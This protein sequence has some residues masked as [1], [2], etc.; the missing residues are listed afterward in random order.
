L[1]EQVDT[2]LSA[3]GRYDELING[4]VVNV[5]GRELVAHYRAGSGPK[6]A[7]N[8]YSVTKTVMSMLI[9]IA[10]QEGRIR[11]VDAT[12]AELLPQYVGVMADGVGAVTLR[13]LL[14]MTGGLAPDERTQRYGPHADWTK[15]TLSTPLWQAPGERFL[16]S[17][18]GAHLLSAILARATG[19][20]VLDYARAKLFDPLAISTHPAEEPVSSV[21][22]LT[23]YDARTGFGWST[24]PQGL[25]LGLAD[26]KITAPDMVKLGRLYLSEGRWDGRRLVPAAWV[27]DSIRRHVTVEDTPDGSAGYGYLWWIPPAPEHPAYAAMGH[28]GQLIHVVPDL[29]LVVAVSCQDAPDSFDATNFIDFVDRQ[30]IPVLAG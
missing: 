27:R 13:Q 3:G 11:S 15:V 28:A 9:G 14:T 26:L 5:D 17:S 2:Y 12:L 25:H 30:I 20:S 4:I 1:Q 7:H 24:D 10:I 19:T 6:D 18:P 16:Y 22:N 23:A 21:D 29:G 8:V